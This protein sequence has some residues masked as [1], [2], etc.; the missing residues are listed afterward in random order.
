VQYD[1]QAAAR[2][3][4][5]RDVKSEGWKGV[6]GRRK[7]RGRATANYACWCFTTHAPVDEEPSRLAEKGRDDRGREDVT[8]EGILEDGSLARV[9]VLADGRLVPRVQG[10]QAYLPRVGVVVAA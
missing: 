5:S 10:G 7:G 8:R 6:M 3:E 9:L 2:G 1:I 4:E